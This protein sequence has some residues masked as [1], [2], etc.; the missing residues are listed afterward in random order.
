MAACMVGPCSVHAAG[1]SYLECGFSD[2]IPGDFTLTDVD[3]RDLHFTMVQLGFGD[4][5]SW[6]TLREEGTENYYAGSA[7]RFKTAKGEEPQ[8]AEDWMV[9]SPVWV[10]A[11]DARL[12]WRG[13]SVNDRNSKVSSYEVLVSAKGSAPEDFVNAPVVYSG[14]EKIHEWTSHEVSLSEYVGQRVYIAFVNRSTESDVLA[15]DDILVEGSVGIADLEIIPGAYTLGDEEIRF[16]GVLTASSTETINTLSISFTVGDEEFHSEYDGL[17]LKPGD[18]FEFMLPEKVSASYGDVVPFTVK[19][20]VNGVAF[21]DM[22]LQ[23]MLLAFLPTK[24]VVVEEV[25]GMWCGYCPEGIVAMETLQE[26]YPE[27]FVGVAVHKDDQLMVRG[28][29]DTMPFPSGA[30]TAWIDR[31]VYCER[32]LAPITDGG[33]HT[34]TTLMG[35]IESLM[36]ERLNEQAF[37]DIDVA[38]S[39]D[40]DAATVD[41]DVAVRFARG[42]DDSDFRIAFLMT[43]DNVWKEGYYQTNYHSGRDELLGGFESLPPSITEDFSFNHVARWAGDDYTGVAGSLPPT[44][45]AG[46]EYTYSTTFNMPRDVLNY[47]NVKLIAM[48]ADAS[49]GEIMNVSSCTMANAGIETTE[50]SGITIK[51]RDGMVCV[52]SLGQVEI[53]VYD[54][55]GKPVR[56][57][58]GDDVVTVSG[59][60]SGAYIVNVMSPTCS[61]TV[62]L[63]M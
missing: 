11:S 39:Y 8:P 57:V 63:L 7:S 19:S 17:E 52:T 28:Y 3:A 61:K 41:V 14:E 21:D 27:R 45:T 16:G 35:G 24:R 6:T 22:S 25:T 32:L 40:V 12:M 34:Y 44:L 15:I 13:M 37:A 54:I 56:R 23:T 51:S 49:T 29:G 1:H 31:K 53:T 26:R 62:K 58:S 59:L 46:N 2:G 9:T 5:D 10:R 47:D 33:R 4:K 43:E 36:L 48:V 55:S 50:D 18:S 60:S 42:Y 38:G 20:E 30:P